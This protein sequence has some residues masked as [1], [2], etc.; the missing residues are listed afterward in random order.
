V[1]GKFADGVK[2]AD[3]R[4]TYLTSSLGL[5]HCDERGSCE[6]PDFCFAGLIYA[7]GGPESTAPAQVCGSAALQCSMGEGLPEAC[8]R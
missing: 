2:A 3:C 6:N 4:S 8:Y 1:V 7:D 5:P